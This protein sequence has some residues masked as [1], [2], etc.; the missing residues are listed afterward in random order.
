[1]VVEPAPMDFARRAECYKIIYSLKRRQSSACKW[2]ARPV[3]DPA[4][5]KDYKE[6]IKNT[7]DLSTITSK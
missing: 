3:S 2:F 4:I 1:M 7:M 6:K 5:V